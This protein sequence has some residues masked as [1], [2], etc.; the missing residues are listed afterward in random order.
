MTP[1]VLRPLVGAV[2]AALALVAT[3]ALADRPVTAGK[4]IRAAGDQI[5][6]EG[7]GSWTTKGASLRSVQWKQH[8]IPVCWINPPPEDAAARAMV[9]AAVHDVWETAADVRVTG[10][11]DCASLPDGERVVRITVSDEEWPRAIVGTSA[12]SRRSPTMWLNFHLWQHPS[13]ASCAAKRDRCL[14]FSA[15]HEF[16]HML[17]LIHEQDRPD[18]PADCITRLGRGQRQSASMSDLDMLTG[19]DPDSLMNYC[20][21]RGYNPT[22][23]LSLTEEDG[24]SIRKLF[25]EPRGGDTAGNDPTP[26][27]QPTVAQ[28]PTRT[29]VRDDASQR[30]TTVT[31]ATGG[32]TTAGTTTDANTRRSKPRHP[33]FDPN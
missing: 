6:P 24:I 4:A 9:R 1:H 2:I 32:T 23:P 14:R 13:F 3:P 29:V 26:P 33:V 27:T 16:G 10:W 7:D 17:G 19:Y 11:D 25:G 21:Y 12:L 22:V 31:P 30:Q 15:V 8:E 20:S 5:L 18:T 28:T